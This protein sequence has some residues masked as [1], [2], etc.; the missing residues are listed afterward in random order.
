MSDINKFTTKEVLNK[1]LLDSSGNSVA[2]NSHTSQEALNAVLDTSNNRL[3]VSLGG[4]NTISGDVTI[5]G[6][7]TVQGGGSQAFDEIVQGTFQIDASASTSNSAVLKLEADRPNSDQDSG[8]IRFYNQG[9]SDHDYARIVGVRGGADN[10]GS[11]QFRTSEAGT[12]V[13]GMTISSTGNV[14]IGTTS[15]YGLLNVS[16]G[17]PALYLEE[18]DAGSGDKL[19]NIAVAGETFAMNCR[20]DANSSGNSFFAVE[21]TDSSI[22]S[23]KLKTGAGVDAIHID[24]NQNV[25]IGIDSGDGTLH[26]HT[27]TAGSVTADSDADDLIVENSA[28]GGISILTPDANGGRI[29]FGSPSDNGHGIVTSTLSGTTMTIGTLM[30]GGKLVFKSADYTTA[31]TIDASQNVG[32]GTASPSVPLHISKATNAGLTEMFIDNSSGG[33]STDETVGIRFL[34]NGA[35]AGGI[36]AGRTEDFSNSANRSGHLIFKTNNDDSYAERMRIDSSGNV[37]IGTSSP[38]ALLDLTSSTGYSNLRLGQNKTNESTQRAGISAQPYLTAEEPTAGMFMFVDGTGSTQDTANLQLGGGHGSFNAVKQIQFYTASD[39][40]TTSG[41]EVMRLDANSRISLSNN[42]SG[43][44]G[45]QNSTSSNTI[46]GYKAGNAI[47]SGTINNTFIGHNAGLS[48][49]DAVANVVIGTN[50]ADALTTGDHN[51]VLGYFAL[52]A[53][54][55]VD[56]VVAIGSGAMESG[57]VTSGADGSIAIGRNSL[58]AL[59]SGARN[60]AVGFETLKALTNGSNNTAVGHEAL[61]TSVDGSSNTAIGRKALYTFEGG[62]D[63]GENTAV[64]ALSSFSLTTGVSNVSVGKGAL[65]NGTSASANVAI[66]VTAM[67]LGT[68]TGV[69]YN[70][71]VGQNALYD[72]TSGTHNVAVGADSLQDLTTASNNVAVGSSAMLNATSLSQSVAVGRQAMGSGV[73]TGSGNIAIGYASMFDVTSGENNIGIG[74]SALG[75]ILGGNNNIA[76]GSNSGET[77]TGVSSTV[78]IGKQA[79]ESI[80]SADALGSVAV[81]HQALKSNTSGVGNTAVGY[82]SLDA[83]DDGDRNTA[84]GY[85]ALTTLNASS[86]TGETT[87]VG[88]E[89]GADVSTGTANTFVGSRAGNQGTNDITTG[90]NNTMI[91]KETRGSAD[92]ASNQTVIGASAV[93]QGDNSVTLGNSSVTDVYAS[94]DGG[95]FIHATGIKFPATQN[96]SSSAN[97]LDDYEEGEYAPVLTCASSGTFGLDASSNAFAYTKIGRKVHVQGEIQVTSEASSPSGELRL[98][99]PFT[100]AVTQTTDSSDIAIGHLQLNASGTSLAGQLYCRT[101]GG[102]NYMTFRMRNDDCTETVLDHS[103]VDTNFYITINLTYNA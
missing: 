20:N 9:G 1:V 72:L 74:S 57:N 45:G 8:E 15:S 3:N 28:S 88:F 83:E 24:S 19:W 39:A 46:I 48:A 73:A 47:A 76:I 23:I 34:H 56:S 29:V 30:S 17:T 35:T 12:E 101:Q 32:I 79:G 22:D 92:D 93:G 99:L 87:A 53:S 90:S 66:G 14:S 11:L 84:I 43:G 49:N 80:N 2:A 100:T 102:L 77:M 27:A 82:L 58:L 97:A 25:G 5:T 61:Y 81:G 33:G 54:T 21:R 50:T 7:L 18:S 10:S 98:T 60:V 55:D 41:T 70:V 62:S 42:D 44:T 64:G 38:D 85:K 68:V 37:G 95:A 52:S 75:N 89:A 26:V 16:G 67:G 59:T 69:G 65:A 91:G 78:L 40:V 4:S 96:A 71:A 86:G 51:V 103:S 6:D 94:Q 31:M 63:A 13:T 36:L